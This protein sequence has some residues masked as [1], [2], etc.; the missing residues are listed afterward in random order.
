MSFLPLFFNSFAAS[1]IASS[2]LA[3]PCA[4]VKT[5][6]LS[7]DFIPSNFKS[8]LEAGL[9][10]SK[11]HPLG[12]MAMRFPDRLRFRIPSQIP[13]ESPTQASA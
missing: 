11:S 9:N 10:I 8:S 2:P 13:G 7:V 12:I 5:A 4:P 3:I 6:T 1:N